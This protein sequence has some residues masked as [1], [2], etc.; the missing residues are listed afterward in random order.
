MLEVRGVSKVYLTGGIKRAVLNN[1]SINFRT[2][3]FAAILGPSGSGKTTFLNIIGGL[4]DY[5]SGDLIINEKST[6]KFRD[7]DWDAYRN[8]R[9][10]FVF[11]SYNLIPHQTVLQNVRL[12]LTLSGISKR[13]SIIRSKK[14]LKEV[15]LEEHIHKLPAQLSGGQM[16]R[17]AI[18]RALVNDPDILLADEPTGALDSETSLQVM[19]LLKKIAKYKLVIMVTH[20]PDLAN[21]YATR[22]INLK[23]GKITADSNPYDGK[24]K[25]DL[26]LIESERKSKK[27]KMSFITAFGLSMRN[28]LTKKARTILVAIAG[29]IGIIGIAL[30]SA[31]STGFQNYI[32][33]IEEDTL[34]S[35][36][37]RLQKETADLT[38]IL[39]SLTGE[40]TGDRQD[41]VLIENQILTSTLGTVSN[42][43]LP[44][45]ATYLEAHKAEL[46]DD[47]RM[48]EYEYNVDPV[49]YTVDATGQV[50]K[51]NPSNMFSSL[52]GETSLLRNYSTMTSVFRQFELENLQN[53]TE[54]LA[55]RYPNEYNEMIVVLNNRNQ[56][57]ELLT[58]SLGFHDSQELNEIISKIMSGERVTI[59]NKPLELSY[60]DLMNVDLRLIPATE[61]FKF[62]SKYDVYEDMSDDK[63][64]MRSIYN[65][66]E[67][68]HI[69]GVAVTNTEMMASESGIAYLPSLITHI[70]DL[71]GQTEIVKK[72]LAN[73]DVDIFS[74]TRFGEEGNDY[75]FE[76]SDLVSIDENKLAQA[77]GVK[78]DQ[79]AVAAKTSEYIQQISNDITADITPVQDKLTNRFK[80]LADK[81]KLSIA[82]LD[83][84][85]T[86]LKNEID[87]IVDE[88]LSDESFSDF[89]EEYSIPGDTFKSTFAGLLKGLL[90]AYVAAFETA[91]QEQSIPYDTETMPIP[92]IDLLF[93]PVTE[94]YLEAL[95]VKSA[96]ESFSI[97]ITEVTMK[98]EILTKVGE[99]STYLTNSFASAF[100]VD[101]DAII[102]AF[103]LNFSEDELSRVVTAMFT[104]RKSTLATNLS[105]LGYQ[106]L[107]DPTTMS[108]YFWSFDGKTHFLEFLEEYNDKMRSLNMDEKVID[109]TDTTG[110]L[111]SSVK[112]IVD[113]VSYVLIAFV[114]ISLIVSS[115][116]IGVITYI[117]V[118]ERTKEIGIL[119]AIGASKHNISSIFNAETFIIGLLSGLFGVLI[120]YLLVPIINLIL[121]HFTGDI[122]LSATLDIRMALFLIIL[123]IVLTLIGGLIPARSASKK[124][125]VEALRSE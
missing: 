93:S 60:D 63:N 68:L 67:K 50:A 83:G 75:N 2:S 55:G 23:D 69:V 59:D 16:Q 51:M 6:K 74:N 47:I 4:D 17:V 28:L 36:P 122:P 32:D 119:R 86:F 38:G 115:I 30:I 114:S 102:G 104:K 70:V 80:D 106:D 10:G 19:D 81:L 15:G 77:F 108:F 110:V 53:N 29:S 21:Q 13:E 73:P 24:I 8:H 105:A 35:Y 58:Y 112:T 5:T 65:N 3:E 49:I 89:E 88:F 121:H 44:S 22:I 45:F 66:A 61:T 82:G 98:K 46:E 56:I 117:S 91:M 95:P 9:I 40:T 84:S 94:Q 42:N 111:M 116:M 72:Q 120:S 92:I 14:V 20:N 52:I 118:Y 33:K 71:S 43:D 124:D 11:Q 26:D 18:A 96:I 87:S 79:N 107:D 37:L 25:T 97:A 103:R 39:L 34:T 1:V 48:V 27:T 54:L 31:V 113:A 12:A 90:S 123:S 100:N 78:I 109:Y 125:P 7:K 85:G 41:G 76:F 101:K 62:N 57:S 99:L 64:Y